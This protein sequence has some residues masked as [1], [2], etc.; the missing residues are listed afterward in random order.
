MIVMGDANNVPSMSPLELAAWSVEE[1]ANFML[2]DLR[3]E[4]ELPAFPMGYQLPED[5]LVDLRQRPALPTDRI[6]VIVDSADQ[7]PAREAAASLRLAGIEAIALEGGAA[8]FQLKV[9]DESADDPRA[10]SYRIFASGVS[11]FG[12]DAPAAPVRKKKAPPKRKKK[13]STGCS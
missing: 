8:A 13:K 5:A 6:V 1:R 3:P 7:G 11:P 12:G 4:G 10:A 9:M 2:F